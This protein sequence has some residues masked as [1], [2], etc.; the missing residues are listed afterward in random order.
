MA[1]KHPTL[2]NKLI[3]AV[4][5][6]ACACACACACALALAGVMLGN[7]DGLEGGVN[8]KKSPVQDREPD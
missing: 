4:S 6:G 1:T 3:V 2:R 8:Q 7:A 5:S